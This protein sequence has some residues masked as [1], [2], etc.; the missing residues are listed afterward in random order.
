M[1]CI[2]KKY[3][4]ISQKYKTKL[5][6]CNR[7]LKLL[8]SVMCDQ[9]PLSSPTPSPAH[10]PH[11]CS[12]C[13]FQARFLFPLTGTYTLPLSS[14]D[15]TGPSLGRNR[16]VTST[17]RPRLHYLKKKPHTLIF[18]LNSLYYLSLPFTTIY[19]LS[20]KIIPF[21]ILSISFLEQE[22]HTSRAQPF[23]G[24][25]WAWHVASHSKLS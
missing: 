20:G 5:S 25:H 3:R 6:S 22:L 12:S 21:F 15:C 18:Y 7:T 11:S 4:M 1:I 17:A 23:C 9:V 10:P 16:I 24:S 13:W 2:H 19:P 14:Q 8:R